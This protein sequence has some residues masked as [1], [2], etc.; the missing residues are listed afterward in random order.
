M[1]LNY[2]WCKYESRSKKNMNDI[3]MYIFATVLTNTCTFV[4]LTINFYFCSVLVNN[5]RWLYVS[6]TVPRIYRHLQCLEDKLSSILMPALT[7]RP[8]LCSAYRPCAYTPIN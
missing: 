7:I 8:P 1:I 4:I 6:R 2:N 5:S 3:I